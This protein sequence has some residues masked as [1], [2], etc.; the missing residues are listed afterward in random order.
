MLTAF[1][2]KIS[3]LA[4]ILEKYL[5]ECKLYHNSC[6]KFAKKEN[7]MRKNLFLRKNIS[8][9][10][11]WG[12]TIISALLAL[13]MYYM[14]ISIPGW[15]LPLSMIFFGDI[16]LPLCIFIPAFLFRNRALAVIGVFIS[17][18]NIVMRVAAMII[19]KKTYM[20][21]DYIT[22]KLLLQHTNFTGLQA[23][24]G[25]YFYLWLIPS[26]IAGASL[27]FFCCRM[28]WKNH[29]HNNRYISHSTWIT[30]L[31]LTLISIWANIRFYK[32]N[33]KSY[34][35]YISERP[36][37]LTAYKISKDVIDEILSSPDYTPVPISDESK[38]ILL[39]MKL[40]PPPDS[41]VQSDKNGI[42]FDRIIIIAME[43]IDFAY[44]RQN[45]PEMPQGIT[46][47]LDKLSREYPSMQNYYTASAPTS[48]GLDAMINSRFDFEADQHIKPA[49][50]FHK[51]KEKGFHTFYISGI[52]GNF[53]N[54]ANIYKDL[55]GPDENIFLE[56]FSEQYGCEM[57]SVWGL[58]DT[59][60]LA[61]AYQELKNCKKERFLA[62]IS[63]IDSHPP[64]HHFNLTQDE[65]NK[66]QDPFLR[67]LLSCDRALGIFIDKLKNDP[68]FYNERTLVIITS[69]HSAT[70]GANFTKR[71][72]LGL[73]RIPL[74]FMTP[75]KKVFENLNTD[76]LSSSID[77]APTILRLIGADV[78]STFMGRSL[79]SDKNCAIL[80]D[81]N[82][83][84]TFIF[85]DRTLEANHS[86]T[87]ESKDLQALADYFSLFY[88]RKK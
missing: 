63:T 73:D 68:Q 58:T 19:F 81:Y 17:F 55:F 60:L 24:M 50:M 37:P 65:L 74:I 28:V 35:K 75:N 45:N 2:K 66:Y 77:L 57:E 44:I 53:G 64:Y 11:V 78:P 1:Y 31:I 14:V 61:M 25:K 38:K 41:S 87:Y 36:I 23:V 46:T 15:H 29:R 26:I 86:R 3:N 22:L 56:Y 34:D 39:D 5:Y 13:R 80:R 71:A 76:K 40:L 48:W 6:L 67:S 83:T 62:V 18:F 12:L 8:I 88:G 4:N 85:P 72:T 30:F 51:A 10:F 82:N 79:F 27:I 7:F 47:N 21:F 20:A 32:I 42:L 54:N 33:Q 52:P 9:F 84:L 69:D 70:H 59:N 49:S 16:L 43:S